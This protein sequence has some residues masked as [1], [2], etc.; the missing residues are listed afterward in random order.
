MLTSDREFVGSAEKQC[1]K[2]LF[3]TLGLRLYT[4]LRVGSSPLLAG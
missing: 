1:R 4:P 3:P 2:L